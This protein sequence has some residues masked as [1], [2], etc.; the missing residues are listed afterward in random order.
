MATELKAILDKQEPNCIARKGLAD[1]QRAALDY[2][3][4]IRTK[5]KDKAADC[6]MLLTYSVSSSTRIVRGEGTLVWERRLGGGRKA[7]IFRLYRRGL[8]QTAQSG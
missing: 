3:A 6:Q 8:T 5:P 2:F 4:D 1:T 7:E